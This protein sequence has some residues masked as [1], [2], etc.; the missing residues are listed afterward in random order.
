MTTQPAQPPVQPSAIVLPP[1]RNEGGNVVRRLKKGYRA[2]RRA[3]GLR[4]V[5]KVL[6]L[7]KAR[8]VKVDQMA[9]LELFGFTGELHT[10]DYV[11]R[12]GTLEVWEIDPSCEVDLKQN[13]PKARIKI[14][15]SVAELRATTSTFD[16]IVVDNPTS[17]FGPYCEHFELIPDVFRVT[18]DGGIILLNVIPRLS[19]KDRRS[20]PYLFSAEHLARRSAFYGTD[21]PEEVSFEKMVEVYGKLAASQ[22][23]TLNWWFTEQRHFVYYLVMSIGKVQSSS[24]AGA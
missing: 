15:D 4:P 18:R 9:G 24:P 13:L 8:G 19:E 6:R 16:F 10:L 22:G 2:L 7:L 3:V 12:I 5:C 17:T 11:H 14:T 23:C 20:H 1:R 21:R